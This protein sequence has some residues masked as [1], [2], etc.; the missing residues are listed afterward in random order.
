[1][2]VGRTRNARRRTRVASEKRRANDPLRDRRSAVKFSD[3]EIFET[4]AEASAYPRSRH[5]LEVDTA[6][7]MIERQRKAL[8]ARRT[9]RGRGPKILARRRFAAADHLTFG[10]VLRTYL[11]DRGKT[12]TALAAAIGVKRTRVSQ[13]LSS[14][15]PPLSFGE[16]NAAAEFLRLLPA[17]HSR[18]LA[19]SIVELRWIVFADEVDPE[20]AKTIAKFLIGALR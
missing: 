4:F 15:R 8:N 2:R 12:Q 16:T 13:V 17:Q 3:E 18:L 1:M 10:E 7:E 20:V 6:G 11:N 5:K 14:R 9:Y 19:L